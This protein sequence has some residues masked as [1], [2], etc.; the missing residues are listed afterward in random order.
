LT[1]Y[2]D[3]ELLSNN[4]L[5]VDGS[6]VEKTGFN[7]EVPKVTEAVLRETIE[8]YIRAEWFPKNLV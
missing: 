6:A 7:Y 3:E 2:L 5:A 1:P 8:E 4:G